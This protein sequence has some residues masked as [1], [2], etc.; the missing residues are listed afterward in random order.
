[1]KPKGPTARQHAWMCQQNADAAL[2][3]QRTGF[4]LL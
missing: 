1:M 2:D 4:L 3:L